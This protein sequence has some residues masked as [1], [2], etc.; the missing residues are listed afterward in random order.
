MK[1]PDNEDVT[2]RLLFFW[3]LWSVIGMQL[4]FVQ[5]LENFDLG[6]SFLFGNHFEL[7][8]LTIWVICKSRDLYVPEKIRDRNNTSFKGFL[9]Q[10]QG[11]FR[12]LQ[13]L[14]VFVCWHLNNWHLPIVRL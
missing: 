8:N 5:F 7:H 12:K 13:F 1:F 14:I 10:M 11:D 3:C 4:L 2:A 9:Y 6:Q